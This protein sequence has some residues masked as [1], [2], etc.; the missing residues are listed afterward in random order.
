MTNS[1]QPAATGKAGD[2][3]FLTGHWKIAHRQLKDNQWDAFDGDATVYAALGGIASVEE[4][5]IPS[6]N[7]SGMGIRLLDVERK[8]WAD[9]WVNRRSGILNTP[10]WGSFTDGVGVWDSA[11]S[12]AA[13]ATLV[14]GV[15]DSI[16]SD[17]CRW[18]QALS[19][20]DGQT[21]QENWVMHWVRA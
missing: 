6:R 9:H 15:W 8:L 19:R 14:R 21:W 10:A 4:L 1:S 18:H 7:F 3:D 2:F 13:G 12:D 16:S 20:D 17:S 5:R 11:D